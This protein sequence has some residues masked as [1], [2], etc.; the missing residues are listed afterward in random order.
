M[1]YDTKRDTITVDDVVYDVE[2][3]SSHHTTYTIELDGEPVFEGLEGQSGWEEDASD[4]SPRDWSNVGVMSC[5]YRGYDLGDEDIREAS[6]KT[7]CPVCNDPDADGVNWVVG[8]HRTGK[9]LAV[10]S[11]DEAHK[12]LNELPDVQSGNY[13]I[14]PIIPEPG[15]VKWDGDPGHFRY[16]DNTM[17][18][19][20]CGGEGET[21]ADMIDYFKR[22]RGARVVLPLIVYEHSGITMQVGH[23]GDAPFDSQGWDT[24]FVGFIFDTPET[25]EQCLG[26]DATDEQIEKALRSEVKDYAS[27]L[28]GDVVWWNVSDDETNFHEGCGGYVGCA[29]TAEQECFEALEQAIIKRLAEEKERAY[30]REREV[31]TV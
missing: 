4:M 21:D 16:E 9:R 2:Q 14:E 20:K 30:W 25:V 5:Y 24:S 31:L 7:N 28:E 22:E 6:F 3:S 27:Y 10:G 17:V 15:Y 11:K 29:D 23:V 19:Q 26:K 18:C 1:S 8:V 12:F 13:Y